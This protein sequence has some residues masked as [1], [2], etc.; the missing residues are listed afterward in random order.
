MTIL[1]GNKRFVES[2]FEYESDFE[3]LVRSQSK[4]LFGEDTIFIYTKRKLKGLVLGNTIP[5][6]FLFDLTDPENPEFY[7]V[8][9]E[10]HW[11]DFHKHMLSQITK[12]IGF[13]H[14]PASQNHLMENLFSL[15]NADAALRSEFKKHLGD[16]EI[17]MFLNDIYKNSQNVLVVIDGE[18]VQLSKHRSDS[19][20]W[21]KFVRILTVK[22]FS[23]ETETL[24]TVEPDFMDFQRTP[25]DE[26]LENNPLTT[27]QRAM[28]AAE[29]SIGRNA[30]YSTVEA[31][32]K[33]NVSR[34]SAQVA[35]KIMRASP[36]LAKQVRSG[37]LSLNDAEMMIGTPTMAQ[38]LA[39]TI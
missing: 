10:V 30:K 9:V 6:G 21:T 17:S 18:N 15:I 3:E 32:K 20:D 14:S 12:F 4:V 7:L 27:S 35:K 34:D 36:Q 24:V 5:D 37:K 19:K 26:V 33:L 22:K 13:F 11:H 1:Q 16:K 39:K 23:N 31:I 28:M 8:E 29:I 25:V 2:Q 38:S